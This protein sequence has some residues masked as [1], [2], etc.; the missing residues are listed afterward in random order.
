MGHQYGLEDP[1]SVGADGKIPDYESMKWKERFMQMQTVSFEPEFATPWVISGLVLTAVVFIPMGTLVLIASDQIQSLRVR[2][3]NANPSGKPCD[4]NRRLALG[5]Q[6]YGSNV[7]PA[8]VNDSCWTTVYFNV[9]ETMDA[10]V[11]LYYEL[12]G[13][14][15]NFRRLVNSRSDAQLNADT[16][17]CQCRDDLA[18]PPQRYAGD[19]Y[20]NGGWKVTVNTTGETGT[21]D[22]LAS[23]LTYSPCGQMAWAMFN[24][25]YRIYGPAGTTGGSNPTAG[26]VVCDTELFDE[27]GNRP[28]SNSLA[29]K[30]NNP[31]EKEGI[32]WSGD[33]GSDGRYQ[34]ATMADNVITSKGMA[35]Y[36]FAVYSASGARADQSDYIVEGINR[37]YYWR[38]YGHRIPSPV[39]LD[40]AVWSRPATLP[41]FR[42]LHRIISGR[43]LAPG[44]Y[45]LEV[46]ERYPTH[47]FS[48]EKAVVL[49]TRS[50]VGADNTVLGVAY[51]VIGSLAAVFSVL[52]FIGQVHSPQGGYTPEAFARL[53]QDAF[54]QPPPKR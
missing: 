9:S 3:D 14:N 15:Q 32:A 18:C 16:T 24:D 33:T 27:L 35:N 42:K 41:T 40:F 46:A 21:K 13:F 25:S 30:E 26:A 28:V 23:Q 7:T 22:V 49:A 1:R 45:Q 20:D 4:Y 53:D 38:E 52:F 47:S 11:Y 51:I 17:E 36:A 34:P 29:T 44:K 48:G 39:D 12:T 43:P 8:Q 31:C 10:P 5:Q 37:G 54:S 2:Y 50:W 6:M 19:Y